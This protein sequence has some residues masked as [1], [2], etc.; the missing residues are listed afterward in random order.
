MAFLKLVKILDNL[1]VIKERENLDSVKMT[2]LKMRATEPLAILNH[3]IRSITQTRME[4]TMSYLSR[5][6]K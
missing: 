4:D 5:D 3:S 2:S 1:L 6:Y